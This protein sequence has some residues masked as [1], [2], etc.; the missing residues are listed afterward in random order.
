M[1]DNMLTTKEIAFI[2]DL[3]TAEESACKKARL[4]SRIMTNPKVAEAFKEIA[5][6]HERRFNA[7]YEL[8]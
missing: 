4:Y 2:A 3:L 7:L 1:S 8:I 6:N 5:D